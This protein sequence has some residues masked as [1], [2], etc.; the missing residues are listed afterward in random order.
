MYIALIIVTLISSLISL[1]Y[2]FIAL[3]GRTDTAYYAFVRSAAA[4]I[5]VIL[6]AL[7][8]IKSLVFGSAL[9]M[10]LVQLGDTFVGIRISDTTKTYGPLGVAIV[11]FI[12]LGLN[13][14]S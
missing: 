6:A 8:N 14:S 5:F 4:I 11:S 13:V 12:L 1:Y 7:L 9:L 3:K 2:A 10:A